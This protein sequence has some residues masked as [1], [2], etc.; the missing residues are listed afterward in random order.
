[1]FG[2][3]FEYSRRHM[4]SWVVA[5][6]LGI[7]HQTP[8]SLPA[9]L[10]SLLMVRNYWGVYSGVPASELYTDHFW[11]LSVEEHFYLLL[12]AV[13]VFVRRR[14]ALLA[15]LS[16]IAYG[17]LF[18]FLLFGHITNNLSLSRTDLRIHGLLIPALLA[19]LLVKPPVLAFAHRWLRPWFWIGLVVVLG[20]AV[21][22]LSLAREF[23]S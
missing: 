15:V 12:P 19:V 1:M 3:S 23:R 8:W 9:V 14:V 17:W 13:L 22:K 10:A 2:V 6:V 16:V 4:R 20:L 11:S 21:H 18:H 5:S 7:L